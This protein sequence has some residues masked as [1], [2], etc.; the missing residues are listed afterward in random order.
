MDTRATEA[1]C[2]YSLYSACACVE[3]VIMIRPCRTSVCSEGVLQMNDILQFQHRRP[4]ETIQ[5]PLISSYVTIPI[6]ATRSIHQRRVSKQ[7]DCPCHRASPN[8]QCKRALYLDKKSPTYREQSKPVA[9]KKLQAK[10]V[11]GIML[12]RSPVLG[13]ENAGLLNFESAKDLA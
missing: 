13:G 12:M 2:H 1:T 10:D 5:R 3:A 11:R 8:P 4:S 6:T 9:G 7:P